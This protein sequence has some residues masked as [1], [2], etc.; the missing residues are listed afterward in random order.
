MGSRRLSGKVLLGT[1][2]QICRVAGGSLRTAGGR[3]KLHWRQRCQEP[4]PLASQ[5]GLGKDEGWGCGS[6][7]LPRPAQPSVAGLDVAGVR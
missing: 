4:D 6:D 5:M 7:R 3:A 1:R 2:T